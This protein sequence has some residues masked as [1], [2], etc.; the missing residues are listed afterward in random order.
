MLVL[1][2]TDLIDAEQCERLFAILRSLNPRALIETASFGAVPLERVLNTGLFNF[3]DAA[4]AP[5]WMQELR[6]SHV[7]ETEEY[8]ISHFVWRARRPFHPQRFWALFSNTLPSVVRSKGYFWLASRPAFAGNW[9]QAGGV[10]RQG[11]AGSWWVSVP[12]ERWPQDEE[13]RL[14][15]MRNWQDGIGDARQELVFIGMEMDEEWLRQQ[16]D[17]AL[18]SHA[19]MAAGPQAWVGMT[20]PVP[21]WF[22]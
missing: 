18:L 14:E 21:E 19:E 13:S 15:I 6:G 11:L 2:K 10:S 5:G 4:Q 9:S 12:R 3:A 22:N 8:G 17:S 20:D 1:N 16:L 7:P